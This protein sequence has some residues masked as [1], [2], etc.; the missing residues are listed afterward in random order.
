MSWCA[1]LQHSVK[2][3]AFIDQ[4]AMTA[5]P[6]VEAADNGAGSG[7]IVFDAAVVGPLALTPCRDQAGTTQI[8]EMT[9]DSGLHHFQTAGE[10]A[11]A[12]FA[13]R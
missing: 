6:G 7:V 1:T 2:L 9:R 3:A 11:D 4:S 8:G 12:D 10:V 5:H 13:V